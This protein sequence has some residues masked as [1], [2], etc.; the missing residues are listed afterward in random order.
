MSEIHATRRE[1]L[2][3]AALLGGSATVAGQVPGLLA[4]LAPAEAGDYLTP[5]AEY[6]LA[7][8][9]NILYSVCQ[10]C[11][12]QCGIKVKIENG[13][14][15]KIDGNP[16]SPWNMVPHLPYKTPVTQVAAVDGL[17]CPKGQAA[18]QTAYDP[19]RIV[20]VLKR[21]GKRGENKWT[22][23]P[24]DQAV[25]EI[26]EGG[27][28]FAQVPGEENRKVEGLRDLRAIRDPKLMKEL[29]ED[30]RKVAKKEMAL[31]EFKAKYRDAL[32]HLIDPN[33]PDL[34]PKNNQFVFMWG[35]LKAGRGELIRRFVD[36][37]FGST[38]A[39]GHTTVCQGSLYFTGKAMS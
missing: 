37:G 1:F 20:K 36:A 17:L 2:K 8:P 30:A 16:Y 13:L 22:S 12:T 31:A 24:F 25:K 3:T 33:H 10:Q 5:T 34:G 6:P 7:R 38:N 23:I 35:R 26:V 28:L 14:I 11:N 18:I 27:F 39:H 29:A 21:A 19:Y 32:K 9:E 15:A 4:R